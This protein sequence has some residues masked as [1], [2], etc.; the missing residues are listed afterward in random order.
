M[1]VYSMQILVYVLCIALYSVRY[2]FVI[3]AKY[4]PSGCRYFVVVVVCF[5]LFLFLFFNFHPWA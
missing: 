1:Y 3:A 5:F 4:V 2:L